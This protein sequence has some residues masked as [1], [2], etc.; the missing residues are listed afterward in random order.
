MTVVRYVVLIAL[1]T[2]AGTPFAKAEAPGIEERIGRVEG[3]LLPAVVFK[4]EAGRPA[5]IISR[6]RHH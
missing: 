3:G 2:A 6:M 4:G 5:S 1:V